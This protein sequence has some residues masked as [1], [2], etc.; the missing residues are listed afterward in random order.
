MTPVAEID[1][2]IIA[3]EVAWKALGHAKLLTTLAEHSGDRDEVA[4][5]RSEEKRLQN[6]WWEQ[7]KK[8]EQVVVAYLT[9]VGF[10]NLKRLGFLLSSL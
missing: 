5:R 10:T 7:R 8:N 1:A 9:T 4:S 6:V 2:G 3:E